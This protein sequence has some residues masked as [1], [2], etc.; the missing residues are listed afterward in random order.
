TSFPARFATAVAQGVQ[1]AISTGI[2]AG[3]ELTDVLVSIEDGSYHEEDSSEAAFREVARIATAA[4][5]RNAEPFVLETISFCHATFRSQHAKEIE[6]VVAAAGGFIQSAQSDLQRSTL[7]AVVPTSVVERVLQQGLFVSNGQAEF[8]MESA[9]FRPKAE[10][11]D[12]LN[13]WPAVP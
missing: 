11:P 2:L 12:L 8:S 7:T 9:G 6:A 10:P 4:A 3:L 13:A 5:L 1:D